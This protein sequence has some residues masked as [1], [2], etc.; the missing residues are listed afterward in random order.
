MTRWCCFPYPISIFP[1]YHIG[2][3]HTADDCHSFL[4]AS[5]IAIELCRSFHGRLHAR[6][7]EYESSPA[8]RCISMTERA[9]C[10]HVLALC[11]NQGAIR[12]GNNAQDE[13][14]VHWQCFHRFQRP[15]FRKVESQIDS[16]RRSIVKRPR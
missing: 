11:K 14:E 5:S 1:A 8:S 2:N 15:F 4:E 10:A 12:D 3:Y 13:R 6:H 7:R 16:N 9:S